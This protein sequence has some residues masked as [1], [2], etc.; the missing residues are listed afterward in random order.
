M[1]ANQSTNGAVAAAIRAEVG[2]N[3]VDPVNC[4]ITVWYEAAVASRSAANSSHADAAAINGADPAPLYI[5]PELI[6]G[7]NIMKLIDP[8][9]P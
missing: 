8:G 3:Q 5:S 4:P 7:G 2:P 6:S 1:P 9:P